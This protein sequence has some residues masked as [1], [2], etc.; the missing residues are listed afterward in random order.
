MP[1]PFLSSAMQSA[2]QT[3]SFL[4]AVRQVRLH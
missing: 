4:Q 3:K 2:A 1:N